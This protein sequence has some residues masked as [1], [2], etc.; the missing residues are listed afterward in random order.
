[1]LKIKV[2]VQREGV[3]VR[4]LNIKAIVNGEKERATR[5]AKNSY[6][7]LVNCFVKG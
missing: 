3:C 6:L 1:M 2:T 7:E 5:K 4:V